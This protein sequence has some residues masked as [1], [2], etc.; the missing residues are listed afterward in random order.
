MNSKYILDLSRQLAAWESG[1]A[2]CSPIWLRRRPRLKP[3]L[4]SHHQ[5]DFQVV[6]YF[7]CLFQR[8]AMTAYRNIKKANPL[9]ML[10]IA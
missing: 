7:G 6:G 2:T 9:R 5:A 1:T 10:R 8:L 3:G 4:E